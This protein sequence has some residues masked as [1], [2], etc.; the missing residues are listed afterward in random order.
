MLELRILV[1]KLEI[2]F[3]PIFTNTKFRIS[4]LFLIVILINVKIES[5]F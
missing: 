5:I 2:T 3:T 4:Y 1:L